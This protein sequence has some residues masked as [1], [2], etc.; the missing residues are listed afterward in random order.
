MNRSASRHSLI[1]LH[2]A[3][4]LAGGTGLFA[5]LVTVDST[6]IT[7]GRTLFGCLALAV[8]AMVMKVDL[9]VRGWKDF[10][11][12]ALSGMLL[13]VHWI[14]FFH[15]IRLS[16]VAV[17]LLAL[18]TF[19]LFVMILEPLIFG[20]R[21]HR[22][23]VIAAG[24]VVAGLM[25]V[26]PEWNPYSPWVRGLGWGI[27]S[28][29]SYALLS[30]V[31]KCSVRGYPALTV[32][33]H[34]QATACLCVLPLAWHAGGIPTGRDVLLIV[35]LG[36]VFTGLAQGLAVASLRYL[37]ARTVAL[38]YGLEPVYG[39]V[40]GWMVLDERPTVRTIAGGVLILAA[41]TMA[42]LRQVR[43]PSLASPDRQP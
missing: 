38:T 19:P 22:Q 26:T 5:K 27:F 6:Q 24:A 43:A 3:V 39:V 15:S 29:F 23:E 31:T 34:Q 9:R 21:L 35:V 37:R 14:S 2:T 10:G 8:A 18:A 28:A 40:L 42:S 7:F 20:E 16:T 12:M 1:Q 41:V 32:T 13:A 4:L 17:G 33:F 11:L 30:L 36:V 25:L